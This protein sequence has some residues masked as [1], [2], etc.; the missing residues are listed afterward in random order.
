MK[1]TFITESYPPDQGG[2][3]TS[4]L[5]LATALAGAGHALQVLTFDRTRPLEHGDYSQ[6]ETFDGFEVI[7]FGPFFGGHPLIQ[8]ALPADPDSRENMRAAFR[9]RVCDRMVREA[10]SFA[11]DAILVFGISN[12]VLLARFIAA[13]L[14]LPFFAGVRADPCLAMFNLQLR[15]AAQ[16]ALEGAAAVI[17]VNDFVRKRAVSF[18]PALAERTFVVNNA[19][20]VPELHDRAGAVRR[21]QAA[22][23]WDDAAFVVI[24]IG[25]LRETK[26]MIPLLQ[27]MDGLSDTDVRLLVVGPPS[28]RRLCGSAL[29]DLVRSG[30]AHCTGYVERDDVAQWAAGGHAVIM[31][32]LTDG[33]AN[34]LLEGMSLGLCPIGSFVFQDVIRDGEN[35]F[36]V[37]AHSPDHIA[38]VLRRLTDDRALAARIGE[39][40]RRY[41]AR[42]HPPAREAQAYVDI[43]TQCL[44][45]SRGI[46]PRAT[47]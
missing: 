27:A 12:A 21:L 13:E 1:L 42:S 29:D 34:G 8:G 32:S 2:I 30:R 3:A 40:A 31:P 20:H 24:F 14:A 38:A 18:L 19:I 25:A 28:D 10:A 41:V 45:R 44:A 15:A 22:T 4:S 23:R 43:I 35:G 16:W 11:P 7:R 39:A 17:C 33:M 5:R 46:A 26:G 9:R 47:A 36:L 37:D 6:R